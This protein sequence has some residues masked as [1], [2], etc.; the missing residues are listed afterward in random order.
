MIIQGGDRENV[1]SAHGAL[2]KA[3]GR[4][5]HS[6]LAGWSKHGHQLLLGNYSEWAALTQRLYTVQGKEGPEPKPEC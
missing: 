3:A 1:H 6:G 5:W 2:G 4:P